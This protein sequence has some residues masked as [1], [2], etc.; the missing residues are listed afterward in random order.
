[1][2]T[3]RDDAI[4]LRCHDLGEADRII[5]ML[6][7]HNGK[8]RAVAKG[9]RRTKSRFGARVE[10]FSLVDVQLYR[11]RNL[12]TITQVESRSPYARAGLP[13]RRGTGQAKT[14]SWTS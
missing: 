7:R 10:P 11:G 13:A 14:P 9:V 2:K 5:T 3:Y 4:V 12:D 6:S 1:M 8:V